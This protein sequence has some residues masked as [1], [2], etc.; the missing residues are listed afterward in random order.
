MAQLSGSVGHHG[1]KGCRL[2]CGLLGRNKNQGSHYYPAL[3]RPNGFE[4]HRTSS[5]AD[6]DINNLPIPNPD[7]YKRDLFH[8]IAAGNDEE[9]RRRRFNTGIGKPSIFDAIPRILPLPTCFAGDIMHQPLINLAALFLDLW[10]ARPGARDYDRFSDWPW[11]VLTGDIWKKHGKVVSQ[12]AR[13]LPTSFGRTP[14]NPQEK[15]S[16]GYKAWEFLYYF[17]SEGPRVFYG[18]LPDIYYSHF[19]R[20][21]QAI[22]I[23]YQHSI[24]RE[25]LEIAYEL[26]LQW[27]VDFEL[28]YCQRNPNRLHFVRQ[29]VHAL[30]HLARETHRLGPLWLSS[31][32]TME[33]VIGYVGSLLRQPSNIYRNLAA[34]TTRVASSNALVVMWPELEKKKG[35]PMGSKDLGNGY[36]LLA[37]KDI[38]VYHLSPIEQTAL[39]HFF[40]N[41]PE[42]EN[43]D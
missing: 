12:A 11:A 4:T 6:I 10:C 39:T 36:L 34:Q 19:C 35:D 41:Y 1:R 31:Q 29:C 37:P 7:S 32:W 3:L 40:S 24:S 26:L 17:Y 21:V 15:A 27:V 2:L 38:A 20:L 30:T 5:H 9:Y 25:Q 16:S 43:I 14:R 13:F 18:V 8:L 28:L 22:R 23:I 33:R 42:G